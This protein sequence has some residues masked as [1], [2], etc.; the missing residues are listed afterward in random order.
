MRNLVSITVNIFDV[1]IAKRE[2]HYA[3]LGVRFHTK[4]KHHSVRISCDRRTTTT[5]RSGVR[6]KAIFH[7]W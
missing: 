3:T 2:F 1:W 7:T 4:Q 6:T 5:T